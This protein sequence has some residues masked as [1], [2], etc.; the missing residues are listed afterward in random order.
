MV[1]L[2]CIGIGIAAAWV[3]VALMDPS[4]EACRPEGEARRD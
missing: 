2:I 3:M 1:E 4:H